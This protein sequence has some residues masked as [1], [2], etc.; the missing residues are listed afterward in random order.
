MNIVS[1]ARVT[2]RTPFRDIAWSKVSNSEFCRFL[3]LD[4]THRFTTSRKVTFLRTSDSQYLTDEDKQRPI[5]HILDN[6]HSPRF[7]TDCRRGSSCRHQAKGSCFFSHWQ[8]ATRAYLVRILFDSHQPMA[9]VLARLHR[10]ETALVHSGLG[11][12]ESKSNE[13]DELSIDK[14]HVTFA[15]QSHLQKQFDNIQRQFQTALEDVQKRNLKQF[16]NLREDM[17][18]KFEALHSLFEQ[19][20]SF[21]VSQLDE[22]QK[23]LLGLFSAQLSDI[24]SQLSSKMAVALSKCHDQTGNQTSSQTQHKQSVSIVEPKE[25]FG[26]VESP[27]SALEPF[28]SQPSQRRFEDEL[29]EPL[30]PSRREFSQI[31]PSPSPSPSTPSSF[32]SSWSASSVPITRGQPSSMDAGPVDCQPLVDNQTK[33]TDVLK[34]LTDWERHEA[35]AIVGSDEEAQRFFV[36]ERE[37][38]TKNMQTDSDYVSESESD[39]NAEYDAMMK[40]KSKLDEKKKEKDAVEQKNNKDN[41][42]SE[43]LSDFLLRMSGLQNPHVPPAPPRLWEDKDHAAS[44]NESHSDYFPDNLFD[45]SDFHLLNANGRRKRVQLL[46]R[47]SARCTQGSFDW[48]SCQMHLQDTKARLQWKYGLKE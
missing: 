14:Q 11:I 26:D 2:D 41:D 42:P 36:Q 27:P 22:S 34:G 24:G 39:H 43:E 13:S 35:Q 3:A 33:Q 31:L 17:S 10:L 37:A 6:T 9:K 20:K 32:S 40:L 16:S 19:H 44:E 1:V 7:T 48:D 5:I 38:Y 45:D 46:E 28:G 12:S 8:Q 30:Q 21:I 25:L 18:R 23:T 29:K 15:S 47:E 4:G